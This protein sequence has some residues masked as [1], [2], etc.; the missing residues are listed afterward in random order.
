MKNVRI[1]ITG[2]QEIDGNSD[3]IQ[4]IGDG[5]LKK[6]DDGFLIEYTEGELAGMDK[7]ETQ[8]RLYGGHS[9]EL[10]RK[11][12]VN[13][14]LKITEGKRNSCY[15]SSSVGGF[16]MGIYGESVSY[17]FDG[18]KG[19]I[20]LCYNIDSNMNP[21]SKNDVKISVRELKGK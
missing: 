16:M 2:N 6:T 17:E 12:G 4:F 15:Y 8:L 3:T 1:K 5:T 7:T 13:S 19:E 14:E 11:G 20:R 21:I 9:A 10:K 18:N